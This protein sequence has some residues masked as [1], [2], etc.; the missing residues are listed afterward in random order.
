M[1]RP[2]RQLRYQVCPVDGRRRFKGRI[3]RAIPPGRKAWYFPTASRSSK[4]S[5]MGPETATRPQS[6]R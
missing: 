4:A 3:V 5:S 6:L 1:M 2:Q